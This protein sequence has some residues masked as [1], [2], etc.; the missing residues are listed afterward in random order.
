MTGCGV[1]NTP[2]ATS[3][4]IALSGDGHTLLT[5]VMLV[6]GNSQEDKKEILRW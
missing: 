2:K 3:I 4:P 1:F 6:S 5:A